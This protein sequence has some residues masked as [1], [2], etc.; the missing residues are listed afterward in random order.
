[1]PCYQFRV[2]S[3][4]QYGQTFSVGEKGALLGRSENC[5]III[6]DPALSRHH[7]RFF[8]RDGLIWI[9]DL[10]SANA[11]E[12]DGIAIQEAPLWKNRRITIGDTEIQVESD[13]GIQRPENISTDNKSIQ[14]APILVGVGMVIAL[15]LYGLYLR[16]PSSP[17]DDV[18]PPQDAAISW[19]EDAA[20]PF[21]G[22][23]YYRIQADTNTIKTFHF[24]IL[25]PDVATIRIADLAQDREMYR[26]QTIPRY[27][28]D[29]LSRHFSE[30]G[31]FSLSS[32]SDMDTNPSEIRINAFIDNQQHTVRNPVD[33]GSATFRN[34]AA[35]I[36]SSA[37]SLFGSWIH[38]FSDDH[39]VALAR[40][41][42]QDARD[43][44]DVTEPRRHNYLFSALQDLEYAAWL[45]RP[46]RPT[47]ELAEEIFETQERFQRHLD[48]HIQDI[49]AEADRASQQNDYE[50]EKEL[51]QLILT[52]LPDTRDIR[53]RTAHNRLQSLP[54]EGGQ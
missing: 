47:P 5:D 30:S 29:I 42:L 53:Y 19:V 39:L 49:F 31:F 43:D 32:E 4:P 8:M 40:R 45:I 17:T 15:F 24:Q 34:L 38:D 52:R 20:I 9:A 36:E 7:C 11:T 46:I 28:R 21:I 1:M 26:T 48:E 10:K 35:Q 50:T 13:G 22:L 23:D 41:K 27:K 51:L 18:Q 33:G 14:P 44:A 2:T 3:G 25:P 37:R 6:L 12:V 54:R 16:T